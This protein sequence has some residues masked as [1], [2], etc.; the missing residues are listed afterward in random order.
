[1]QKYKNLEFSKIQIENGKKILDENFFTSYDIHLNEDKKNKLNYIINFFKKNK[2]INILEI[3]FG[4][5]RNFSFI[6][7][8]IIKNYVNLEVHYIGIEKHPISKKFI[9]FIYKNN[10]FIKNYF[11]E[12]PDQLPGNH[13]VYSNESLLLDI[14][15]GEAEKFFEKYKGEIDLI[16]IDAYNQ[17]LNPNLWNKK[18]PYQLI[19]LSHLNS[20]ILFFDDIK[21]NCQYFEYAGWF[22]EDDFIAK[23]KKNIN[24]TLPNRI[25]KKKKIA[26]IGSGLAGGIAAYELSQQG[27]QIFLFDEKSKAAQGA[28]GNLAGIFHPHISVDDAYI[29]QLSRIGVELTQS[30]L[31][32]FTQLGVLKEGKDWALTGHIQ[33]YESIFEQQKFEKALLNMK[34][35]E[36][37]VHKL[38]HN[39][40]Q[41]SIKSSFLGAAL[42]FSQAGW[43]RP[44]IWIKSALN[45][46]LQTKNLKIF[47]QTKVTSCNFYNGKWGLEISGCHVNKFNDFDCVVLACSDQ[48]QNLFQ[49]NGVKS[50]SIKGQISYIFYKNNLKKVISGTSYVIP[51]N[52]EKMIIGASFDLN[53]QTHDVTDQ[54]HQNNLKKFSQVFSTEQEPK[55]VGGRVGFRYA[56]QDHLPAI[57]PATDENGEPIEGLYFLTAYGSRGITWAALGAQVLVDLIDQ[58]NGL[59]TQDLLAAVL[60]GRFVWRASNSKPVL[61]SGL[62]TK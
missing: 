58:R 23:V 47:N 40:I 56:W 55:I 5:G 36:K 35:P 29:S 37:W 32:K 41:C 52:T 48:H 16:I 24:L 11:S 61:P 6:I 60:P 20:C 59:L 30:Q 44:S 34:F 43:V 53:D 31:K 7:S 57:G 18:L 17:N 26:V 14:Y 51:I 9:D 3:G 10:V 19:R 49:Q 45:L 39:Q 27:H 46:A 54:A 28:S 21:K 38:N 50:A 25:F 42:Y 4:I 2:K 33:L 22:F 62:S 8:E 1:M 13:R 15:Y 12:W